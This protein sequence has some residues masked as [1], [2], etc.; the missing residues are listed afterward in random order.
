MKV[1]LLRNVLII[2]AFLVAMGQFARVILPHLN[3]NAQ[4]IAQGNQ[5]SLLS[6]FMQDLT[7]F[8]IAM[9]I[10]VLCL[11]AAHNLKPL[12]LFSDISLIKALLL[13]QILVGLGLLF[14]F[15][16]TVQVYAPYFPE[17]S[18]P[19]TTSFLEMVNWFFYSVAE[20]IVLSFAIFQI[21]SKQNKQPIGSLSNEGAQN[22]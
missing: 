9:P 14:E 2:T 20:L 5:K 16:R 22:E 19:T 3:G 10:V 6:V 17:L 1:T 15:I 7:Y 21:K 12:R 11:W 18:L 4:F 13:V 8:F